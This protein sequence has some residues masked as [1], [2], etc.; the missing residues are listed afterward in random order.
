VHDRVLR[1]LLIAGRTVAFGFILILMSI[2]FVSALVI[3]L[4]RL[5]NV[6]LFAGHEWLTYAIVGLVSLIAG[7]IIWRRRRPVNLRK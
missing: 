4:V 3:G 6:Y 2:V 7:L 1:P 5:F